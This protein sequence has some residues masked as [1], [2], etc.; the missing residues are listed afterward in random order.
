[1]AKRLTQNVEAE[2]R[3]IDAQTGVR[4]I[5]RQMNKGLDLHRNR[6]VTNTDHRSWESTTRDILTKS[7][8]SNSKNITDVLHASSDYPL[9]VGMSEHQSE[10]YTASQLLNQIKMLQS[11]IDQLETE[12]EI[13]EEQPNIVIGKINTQSMQ[14][15]PSYNSKVFIVHGH[16]EH[17]KKATARFVDK[18]GLEAIILHEKP[19]KGRTIIE[20]FS[21]YADVGFAIILLTADDYGKS[22][23][24]TGDFNL[25]ARQNVILELGYFLGKL[26]R[27]RVCA[28]YEDGV[29]IP[30]DYQGVLFIPWSSKWQY[31]VFNELKAVGYDVDANKLF[32]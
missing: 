1:M 31:D 2:P 8:G 22:K 26:G 16:N 29:E 3:S 13:S 27:D 25:R 18:L 10:Q 32:T 6:P 20:K 9:F 21:D 7:F 17:L 28:I 23:V 11:C 24:S 4:L 14:K 30:S 15:E 12:I 5:N 19:N